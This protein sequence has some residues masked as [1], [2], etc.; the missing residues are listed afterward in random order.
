[1]RALVTG[2]VGFIGTNLSD[3]LLPLVM[4][5][6]FLTILAA[7][8][9]NIIS[10]GLKRHTAKSCSLFKDAVLTAIQNVDAVFHLAAQVAV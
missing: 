1:M 3:R 5:L 6:F 9:F 4:K 2:G 7:R 8:V 10:I